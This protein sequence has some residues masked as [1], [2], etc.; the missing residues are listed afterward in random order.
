[1]FA[2]PENRRATPNLT[3]D[4]PDFNRCLGYLRPLCGERLRILVFESQAGLRKTVVSPHIGAFRLSKASDR[5]RF[6]VGG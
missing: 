6:S 4:T 2:L 1:M 5:D 3:R